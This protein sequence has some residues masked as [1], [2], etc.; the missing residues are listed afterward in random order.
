MS[1]PY[2]GWKDR[3]TSVVNFY[4][5]HSDVLY[6]RL[7]GVVRRALD[8]ADWDELRAIRAVTRYLEDDLERRLD[9]TEDPMI[10]A[11]V[12]V[13][14]LTE[15]AAAWVEGEIAERREEDRTA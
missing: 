4:W 3:P 13:P 14:D 12:S 2:D 1:G 10:R 11:L 5:T 7:R 8:L 15:I 6:R 9:K